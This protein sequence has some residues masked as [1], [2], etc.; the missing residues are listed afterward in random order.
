MIDEGKERRLNELRLQ[1][2]RN[3]GDDRLVREY[4]LALTHG[5]HVAR[6]TELG[7]IG[8]V[9][10]GK[11]VQ[12]AQI[13][14][15][16]LVKMQIFQIVRRLIHAGGNRIGDEAVG[17]EENVEHRLL[18]MFSARKI[19]LPHRE[20]IEI[21]QQREISHTAP[22]PPSGGSSGVS[23]V[24]SEGC[25]AAAPFFSLGGAGG[26]LSPNILMVL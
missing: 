18:R 17:A 22:P 16:A 12:R 5:V 10:L 24:S 11:H 14:D 19:P 8:E 23:D 13:G 26:Y 9:V 4:D 3:N 20:L 15:V 7:K 25:S 2:R 6:K 21:G 1:H